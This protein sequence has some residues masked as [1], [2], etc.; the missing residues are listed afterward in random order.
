VVQ[1]R[2]NGSNPQWAFNG[3]M[4]APTFT[5]SVRHFIPARE[6][7]PE[8]TFCHYFITD[9]NICY[10]GD[11]DHELSGKTVPLPDLPEDRA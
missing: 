6:G 2:S 3:N 9:G 1:Y 11:C 10:C 7:K 4:E 5:P 8:Y